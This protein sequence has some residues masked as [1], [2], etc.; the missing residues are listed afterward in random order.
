MI[1]RTRVSIF[2]IDLG[3]VRVERNPALCE[4]LNEDVESFVGSNLGIKISV[5]LVHLLSCISY[6]LFLISCAYLV[7]VRST[8]LGCCSCCLSAFFLLQ[9]VRNFVFK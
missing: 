6:P 2:V 8:I 4:L 7:L 3:E 9:P 1:V 5:S